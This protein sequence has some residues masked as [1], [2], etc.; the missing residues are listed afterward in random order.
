MCCAKFSLGLTDQMAR[1]TLAVPKA[2]Q[3]KTRG[4][5]RGRALIVHAPPAFVVPLY[6]Y[7]ALMFHLKLPRKTM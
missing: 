4:I 1:N 2:T 5:F 7:I 6:W 3:S